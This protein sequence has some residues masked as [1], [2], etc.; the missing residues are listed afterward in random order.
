MLRAIPLERPTSITDIE[1]EVLRAVFKLRN[2]EGGGEEL[3]RDTIKRCHGIVQSLNSTSEE[4]WFGICTYSRQWLELK[5]LITD[6]IQHLPTGNELSAA[7][8]SDVNVEETNSDTVVENVAPDPIDEPSTSTSTVRTNERTD[9][10]TGIR[11]H[12]CTR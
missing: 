7:V 4:H 6:D 3:T 5:C 11:C 2:E 8:M 10:S 12:V 1:I 9:V